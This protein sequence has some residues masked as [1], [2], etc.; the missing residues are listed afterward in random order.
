MR[1]WAVSVFTLRSIF[2]RERIVSEILSKISVR[3]PP[4]LRAMSMD[5]QTSVRSSDATRRSRDASASSKGNPTRICCSNTLNSW[6]IGLSP[7]STTLS[8][9]WLME[10]PARRALD[11]VPSASTSCSLNFTR[12]LSRRIFT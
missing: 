12:L 2:M 10:K 5:V 9:A 3:F 4:V 6:E 8:N 7:L 11:I 1:P